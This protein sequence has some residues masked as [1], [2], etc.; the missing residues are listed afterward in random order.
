MGLGSLAD[1]GLPAA[2]QK[3][4]DARKLR[5]T[6]ADPI[7]TRKASKAALA[8]AAATAMTFDACRD[9]Y[10]GAHR[11][12]W[13]NPK[14]PKQ[15]ENSLAKYAS[16]VIGK[17][18]VRDVDTALVMQILEPIWAKKPE[19]ASRVRG[20]IERILDWA[21][22]RG[23]REG[24]NP[25]RWRGHLDHLLAPRF[26]VRSVQHHPA[27]PYAELPAFL[28]RLRTRKVSAQRRSNSRF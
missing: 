25:A 15:W 7:D 27:L 28:K 6:G 5:F 22:V 23:H 10:I 2:R 19:T 14:H 21:K 18:F 12:G 26:K 3:A 11:S 9:A 24:E 17:I 16:P 20:R 13:K 1:V 4:A 8:K